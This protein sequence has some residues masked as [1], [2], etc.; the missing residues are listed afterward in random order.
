MVQLLLHVGPPKTGSTHIQDVFR[1]LLAE[2][3]EFG[4]PGECWEWP[5]NKTGN[6]GLKSEAVFWSELE[7]TSAGGT[8]LR[9][10]AASLERLRQANCSA[11]ISSETFACLSHAARTRVRVQWT[12]PPVRTDVVL[13]YR[14]D[15]VAT[16]RSFYAQWHGSFCTMYCGI[17]GSAQIDSVRAHDQPCPTDVG[18]SWMHPSR[19][20]FK[21]TQP[22]R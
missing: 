15:R 12:P 5:S 1:R 21:L 3:H 22:L 19:W 8:L 7:S 16:L 14:S 10:R 11:F 2:R 17:T 6:A 20:L 9:T 13:V 4:R 18:S